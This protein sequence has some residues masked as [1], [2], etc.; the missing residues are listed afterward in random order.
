MSKDKLDKKIDL[1]ETLME[2]P[3]VLALLDGIL[4]NPKVQG[5]IDR[6]FFRKTLKYGLVMACLTAGIFSVVNGLIEG[7]SLGWIGWVGFGIILSLAGGS[8][9]LKQL[10]MKN[11]EKSS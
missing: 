8:Y 3:K 1:A 2:N 10:L 6:I 7:L 4:G 9:T 5:I 11:P